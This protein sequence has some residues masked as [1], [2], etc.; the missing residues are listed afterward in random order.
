[1]DGVYAAKVS[2]NGSEHGAM[3]Y[4]GKRP[5]FYEKAQSSIETYIMGYKGN[6]YGKEISVRVIERI[7]AERK[8]SSPKSLKN[9]IMN[10]EVTA[11]KIIKKQAAKQGG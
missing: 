1:M 3:L 2:V 8:F 11:R 5:T 9:Q 6:L 10:D 7:R 4:L